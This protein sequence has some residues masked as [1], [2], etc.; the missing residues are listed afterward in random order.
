VACWEK[1]N[2]S[3]AEL[4]TGHPQELVWATRLVRHRSR[5]TAMKLLDYL[6]DS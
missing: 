3:L 4:G 5:G 1:K 6:I 2:P